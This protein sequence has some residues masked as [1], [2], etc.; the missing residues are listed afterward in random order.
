[1]GSKGRGWWHP[2]LAQSRGRRAGSSRARSACGRAGSV[3]GGQPRCG[4]LRRALPNP[5]CLHTTVSG[6]HFGH[7]WIFFFFLGKKKKKRLLVSLLKKLEEWRQLR[8]LLPAAEGWWWLADGAVL[9]SRC[10]PPVSSCGPPVPEGGGETGRGWPQW[11]WK[12]PRGAGSCSRAGRV[13][14]RTEARGKQH[15]SAWPGGHLHPW[16]GSGL[17]PGQGQPAPELLS[18]TFQSCLS[19]VCPYGTWCCSLPTGTEQGAP[20][21]CPRTLSPSPND[22]SAV[23][24]CQPAANHRDPAEPS[25]GDSSPRQSPARARRH[26]ARSELKKIGIFIQM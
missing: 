16:R 20:P 13:V 3:P 4:C 24:G 7:S 22:P 5:P 26:S 2:S 6:E 19:L 1:M 15:G 18:C 23:A 9:L 8:A 25:E 17:G 10:S 12:W 14:L 21:L 11:R